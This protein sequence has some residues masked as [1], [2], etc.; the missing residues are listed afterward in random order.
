MWQL[1]CY[2]NRQYANH[3]SACVPHQLAQEDCM[4]SH[5]ERA[6]LCTSVTHSW[7][8]CYRWPSRKH[9]YRQPRNRSVYLELMGRGEMKR[10]S[11]LRYAASHLHGTSHTYAQ[12][13]IRETVENMGAAAM[14]A[15]INK[16]TKY[17]CLTAMHYF[18]PIAI[19][20]REPWNTGAA[21][22]VADL[23]RRITPIILK[24][25]ETQYLFQ[26]ISITL[27]RGNEIVSKHF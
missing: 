25:L 24:P 10:R 17:A 1:G 8:T 14:N 7:M 23:G 22:F 3:K 6:D 4:I 13:H 11:S 12:S 9:K 26:R 19:K 21:V 2:F 15:A 18:M 16:T 20:T 5:A 27:Q